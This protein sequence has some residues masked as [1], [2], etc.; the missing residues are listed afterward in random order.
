MARFT[1][2]RLHVSPRFLLLLQ[3]VHRKCS[4]QPKRL[5]KYTKNAQNILQ[6]VLFLPI[7]Y[8]CSLSCGLCINQV[9][10]FVT[11][12]RGNKAYCVTAYH[13]ATT[14]E[15]YVHDSRYVC[16]DFPFDV[17]STVHM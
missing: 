6:L 4:Q 10:L 16:R 13:D 14:I 7:V 11:K 1:P 3:P 17:G 9:V 5:L 15:E 8:A 2:A 12:K